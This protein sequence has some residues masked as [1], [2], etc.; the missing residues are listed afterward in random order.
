MEYDSLPNFR[1][2]VDIAKIIV[3]PLVTVEIAALNFLLTQPDLNDD[4]IKDIETEAKIIM[5]RA[6]G[7]DCAGG[8][9]TVS[10]FALPA[11]TV[12]DSD[13]TEIILWNDQLTYLGPTSQA[14]AGR[15]RI[16][17]KF[18]DVD[19]AYKPTDSTVA[20]YFMLPEQIDKLDISI[21]EEMIGAMATNLNQSTEE[22]T[23]PEFLT[24]DLA[25]QQATLRACIDRFNQSTDQYVGLCFR[26]KAKRY[27][28]RYR[29]YDKSQSLE[30]VN[31]NDSMLDQTKFKPQ[32]RIEICGQYEGSVFPE[33][34]DQPN[35]AF[36]AITDFPISQGC[37]CMI[38]QNY[39]NLTIYVVPV[40]DIETI[41]RIDHLKT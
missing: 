12:A 30:F 34:A 19:E 7:T 4:D 14:I 38:F 18:L 21:Y 32:D 33:V 1:A 6:C 13:S 17:Y 8:Q 29:D 20:T 39:Q 23:R 41:T 22:L 25:Q 5:N 31:F 24:A 11:E 10:G 2:T 28:G 3:D 26:V 9:A 36:R 40:G 15:R 16:V 35:R 27:T 37:P